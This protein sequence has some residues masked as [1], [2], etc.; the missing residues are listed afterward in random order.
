MNHRQLFR[1]FALKS[2]VILR[3]APT[4]QQLKPK[5]TAS[6]Q[7]DWHAL[8]HPDPFDGWRLMIACALILI[9]LTLVMLLEPDHEAPQAPVVPPPVIS[10]RPIVQPTAASSAQPIHHPRITVA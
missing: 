6:H 2:G 10:A 3:D 8:N 7:P 5:D 9:T 4:Q 1:A